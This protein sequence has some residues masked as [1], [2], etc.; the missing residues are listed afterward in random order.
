MTPLRKW[1]KKKLLSL[2]PVGTIWSD[3]SP[4]A[5]AEL[6]GVKHQQLMT[7]W[8]QVT[9]GTPDFNTQG[10]DPRFTTCSS[11]LPR[12]AMQVRIAGKMP[13][14]H[15]NS[16]LNTDSDIILHG[17]Q[18][19]REPGWVPAFIGYSI[20]SGPK[21]GD[22]FE[23]GHKGMTDHVGIIAEIQGD[24]WSCVAGGGGGRK[25]HHDGVKRSELSP[26]PQSLIGWVDVDVYFEGWDG[27]DVG[28]V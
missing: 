1:I 26:R 18:L 17:F 24:M 27:P 20:S 22:F 11:F 8:Y 16:R 4:A 7:K 23:L 28:D 2:V 3:S 9:D 15:H 10:S 19:E 12:F 21:E 6:T 5:F 13:T 14:K 25:S